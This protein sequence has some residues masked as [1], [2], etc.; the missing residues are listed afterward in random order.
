M[1]KTGKYVL[2]YTK[3]KIKL[4]VYANLYLDL[5]EFF[6]HGSNTL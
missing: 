3:L 2:Y 4:E 5:N 1:S 6:K